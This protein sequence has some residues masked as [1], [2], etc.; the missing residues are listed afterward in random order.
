[1]YVVISQ[2]HIESHSTRKKATCADLSHRRP[3]GFGYDLPKGMTEY[4]IIKRVDGSTV[5][6][7][8]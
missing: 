8:Y 6:E 7:Q 3:I 5:S 4:P 2:F 1:M